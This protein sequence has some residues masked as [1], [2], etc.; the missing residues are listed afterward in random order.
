MM[1]MMICSFLTVSLHNE[2]GKKV[3]GVTF[4]YP[5][6]E[7]GESFDFE[8]YLPIDSMNALGNDLELRLLCYKKFQF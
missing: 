5:R 2:L 1:I 6:C 3:L 8:L 7:G 4:A